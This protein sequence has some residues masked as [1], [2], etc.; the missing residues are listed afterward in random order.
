MSQVGKSIQASTPTSLGETKQSWL[1]KMRTAGM[2]DNAAMYGPK[3]KMSGMEA[4]SLRPAWIAL[5]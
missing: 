4:R 1:S 2:P 3:E 5:A